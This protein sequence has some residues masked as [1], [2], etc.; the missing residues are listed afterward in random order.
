MNTDF[1]VDGVQYNVLIPR[2][3]LKRSGQIL[4]GDDAGRLQNG[5]MERDIIGTYY[6][7]TLTIDTKGMRMS[8]YDAL[9]EVL[10]APVDYHV[11]T[12]PY[13]QGVISFD[14]YVSGVEDNL[15][16][17]QASGN[18]WGGMTVNFVAMAPKRVP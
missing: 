14:A 2:D 18:T 7:Y 10:T 6:N 9:Y 8:E 15:I 4:D 5:C 1:T 17:A 11:V 16:M 3:G 13:G 12:L